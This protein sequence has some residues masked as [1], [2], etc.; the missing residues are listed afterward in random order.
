MLGVKNNSRS[1]GQRIEGGSSGKKY[2]FG[3][4]VIKIVVEKIRGGG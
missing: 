4:V 2:V 3:I 1:K